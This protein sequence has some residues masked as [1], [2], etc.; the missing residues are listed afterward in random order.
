M[1]SPTLF[2]MMVLLALA[3]TV[4]TGPALRLLGIDRGGGAVR[5]ELP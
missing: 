1:I 4:A 2:A 3:K 5:A